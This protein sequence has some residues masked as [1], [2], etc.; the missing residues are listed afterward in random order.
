MSTETKAKA[1]KNITLPS[2]LAK[3]V[4]QAKDEASSYELVMLRTQS[5]IAQLQIAM[6]QTA[7]KREKSLGY[8]K[9]LIAGFAQAKRLDPNKTNLAPDGKTLI[10]NE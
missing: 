5:Q 1:A 10:I 2:Q 9:G 3:E 4:A 8:A 7:Q 6:M